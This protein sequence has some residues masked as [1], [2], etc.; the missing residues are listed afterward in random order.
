M[1]SREQGA[2]GKELIFHSPLCPLPPAPCPSPQCPMPNA[3]CPL[4]HTPSE[5]AML[6]NHC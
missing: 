3:Q 2:E 4:P 1:G 5:I 6:S